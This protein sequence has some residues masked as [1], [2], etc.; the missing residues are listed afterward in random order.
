MPVIAASLPDDDRGQWVWGHDGRVWIA[1]GSLAMEGLV[2]GVIAQQQAEQQS[3]PLDYRL[4]AGPLYG[5][6]L[7]AVPGYLF[8]DLAVP[9][10][11][12]QIPNTLAGDCAQRFYL[13]HVTPVDD[14][15]PLT[16][17]PDDLAVAAAT[18]G[19]VCADL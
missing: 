9:S 13:G 1:V 15:D 18:I 12:E 17:T 11:L 2:S 5:N 16:M 4:L 3:D 14:P 7:Q 10:A 19:G 8:V 6:W